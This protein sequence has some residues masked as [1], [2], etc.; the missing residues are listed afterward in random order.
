MATISLDE[1]PQATRAVLEQ[2]ES[3]DVTNQGAIVARIV[4]VSV[5]KVELDPELFQLVRERVVDLD[6]LPPERPLTTE[7]R[8][9]LEDELA[10]IDVLAAEVSAAWKDDM[11]AAEA[12]KEQRREL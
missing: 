6:H 3:L 7:E 11:S 5:D 10:A 4:P 9:R 12:V 2:G 8:A 1:L